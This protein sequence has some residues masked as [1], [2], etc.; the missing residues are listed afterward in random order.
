[1]NVTLQAIFMSLSEQLA[2]RMIDGMDGD[3]KKDLIIK[4][5]DHL[6]S[7]LGPEDRKDLMVRMFPNMVEK[8]LEGMDPEEKAALVRKVM[9]DVMGLLMGPSER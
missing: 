6:V 5:G 1:M 7:S 9:P 4:L 8:V 3:E 2:E